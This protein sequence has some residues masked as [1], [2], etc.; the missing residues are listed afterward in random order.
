VVPPWFR[1]YMDLESAATLIRAYEG[2]FVPVLLQ[3][4]DYARATIAGMLLPQAPDE[5]ERRVT[6][7]LA[8][9]QILEKPDGPRL[10]AVVEEA[11]LRRSVGGTQ[12]MRGQLER[13][14]DAT[15][16]ANVVLQVLPL[17]V[18]VHPAM[19]GAF[20][21]L[22]F[23]DQELPDVVYVEQLTNAL[24]LDRLDD[25][26][27]Y[28]QVMDNISMRAAPPDRTVDILQELLKDS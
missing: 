15:R 4:A 2:Q 26:N 17:T 14:I 8:R 23:A 16:M 22:R 3:T 9:Q 5:V 21:I 11:A 13:L 19:T 12:V 1:A 27:Q 7:K 10:W 20:S 6:L 18:A 24:Y 28:L 25:V